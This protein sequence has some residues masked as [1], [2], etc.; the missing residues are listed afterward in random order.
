MSVVTGHNG[1]GHGQRGATATATPAHRRDRDPAAIPVALDHEELVVRRGRRSGM[2]M[3][4]AVHSTALGPALGG[5]RIWHYES[6]ADGVRDALRLAQ[7]MTLKAAAAG[8]DLGGGKGVIC[9]PEVAPNGERRRAMLHDFGELVESLEGRYIT[10][11]DVGCC[12]EDLVATGERTAHVVG[13]PAEHG[14]SGD[15]SPYTARGVEAAMRACARARFGAPELAGLRVVVVG[16]GHVGARLARRLAEHDARLAVSDIRVGKRRLAAELGA[17]W[18]E[19][20][21]AMVSE[22]DVLA[23][24]ALGGA[25]SE[26]NRELLRCE[27]VCGSANNQLASEH[28]AERLAERGILFAP[29]FIA[30][31]GGLINVYRELR[32]YEAEE[33]MRLAEEIETTMA[34]ILAAAEERSVTPS[35]A[36]REL[37]VE[38]LDSATVAA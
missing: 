2:H 9:A 14:G 22:C 33:A 36:A 15:P 35:R 20:G 8:L 4:I 32:G 19:P 7:A 38:R 5:M 21:E 24:C 27:V 1:S 30:N 3:A 25:I 37:A 31:A 16:L 28:L 11:E 29:D 17:E 6:T 26:A 18:L 34:L 23:P 10:A 13:L 12:A